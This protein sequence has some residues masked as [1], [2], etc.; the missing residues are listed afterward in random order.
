MESNKLAEITRLFRRA[1][2]RTDI[3]QYLVMACSPD[4]EPLGVAVVA[5]GEIDRCGLRFKD[6][7]RVALER[8]STKKI[9]TAHSHVIQGRVSDA[10]IIHAVSLATQPFHDLIHGTYHFVIEPQEKWTAIKLDEL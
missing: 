6:V 3:E 7:E 8:F 4:D 5:D 9:F 2:T 10:D 1:L